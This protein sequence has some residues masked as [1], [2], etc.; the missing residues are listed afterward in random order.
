MVSWAKYHE[1][2]IRRSHRYLAQTR[3]IKTD[4]TGRGKFMNSSEK[5]TKNS[6]GG[7]DIF[8][9]LSTRNLLGNYF[10]QFSLEFTAI[11]ELNDNR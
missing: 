7:G 4:T 8:I 5:T 11:T 2:R 3:V 9:S 1:R 10:I 6:P